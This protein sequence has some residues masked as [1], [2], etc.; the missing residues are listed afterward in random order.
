[1]GIPHWDELS[2]VFPLQLKEV[3]LVN[4]FLLLVILMYSLF[5]MI[6]IQRKIKF[7]DRIRVIHLFKYK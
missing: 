6:H 7:V 1:M 4:I 5:L 3:S 2:S